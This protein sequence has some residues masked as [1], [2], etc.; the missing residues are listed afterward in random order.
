MKTG[1]KQMAGRKSILWGLSGSADEGQ[2]E[3]PDSQRSWNKRKTYITTNSKI[4][5]RTCTIQTGVSA[6]DTTCTGL[7]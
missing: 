4:K 7:R 6:N 2:T 5:S 3:V 1:D